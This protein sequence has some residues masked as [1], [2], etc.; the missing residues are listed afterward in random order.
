MIR[1]GQVLIFPLARRHLWWSTVRTQLGD[2]WRDLHQRRYSI[3]INHQEIKQPGRMAH[4]SQLNDRKVPIKYLNSVRCCWCLNPQC[5]R[6]R[7][8]ISDVS[9]LFVWLNVILSSSVRLTDRRRLKNQTGSSRLTVPIW[10]EIQVLSVSVE[11]E[12][13][14]RVLQSF[15]IQRFCF[16]LKTT[17]RIYRQKSLYH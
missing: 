8:W 17:R 14:W 4:G 6:S 13:V 9:R 16:E 5:F 3:Y 11:L 7:R 10:K 15:D 2:K 1:G 12:I